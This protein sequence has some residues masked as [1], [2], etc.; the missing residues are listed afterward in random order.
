MVI[1]LLRIYFGGKDM[2]KKRLIIFLPFVLL[3]LFNSYSEVFP[4]NNNKPKKILYINSYYKDHPIESEITKGITESFKKDNKCIIY[5]EYMDNRIFTDNGSYFKTYIKEKY[6]DEDIDLIITA[7]D[8][9]L[10]FIDLNSKEI[11]KKSIPVVFCAI[12]NYNN[13]VEPYS[14]NYSG[15]TEKV[16]IESTFRLARQLN[17]NLE[18]AI[19]IANNKSDI[20]YQEEYKRIKNTYKDKVKFFIIDDKNLF[21]IIERIKP[22][23]Q[24][25]AI[26]FQGEYFD[27]NGQYLS[28]S[29]SIKILN[30]NLSI[31]IYSYWFA[32]KNFDIVGGDMKSSYRQGVM[33]GNLAKDILYKNTKEK[34][35]IN[36]TI[37]DYISENYNNFMLGH[38]YV[39]E[40]EKGD[41]NKEYIYTINSKILHKNNFN[42]HNLKVD[43]MLLGESK[44]HKYKREQ[45]LKIIYIIATFFFIVIIMFLVNIF[46]KKKDKNKFLKVIE[47]NEQVLEEVLTQERQRNELF[48]NIS[49]EFRTPLNVLYN[50]IQL[51]EYELSSI[52]S[53]EE[54]VIVKN[55]L[56][57][58]KHNCYRL[59]RL[60]NN[61]IKVTEI[62]NNLMKL[63]L[64]KVNIVYVIEDLVQEV[65]I[66]SKEKNIDRK[67]I[68]DTYIEEKLIYVDKEKIE[69][70]LLNLISN[71]VKFSVDG[72]TIEVILKEEEDSI[73]IILKDNGIGISEEDIED[74]F[75]KFSKVDKSL[76]RTKEGSGVGLFIVKNLLEFIEAKFNIYS[77]KGE[78]TIFNIEIPIK[79]IDDNEVSNIGIIV[80]DITIADKVRIEFSDIYI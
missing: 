66:Y 48:A 19:F 20:E 57:I 11:F 72:D 40:K 23:K 67:I 54:K 56:P 28:S 47:K 39:T 6:K 9:A 65:V 24:N 52:D 68:F 29:T 79:N 38:N 60:G 21:S 13:S 12:N 2:K 69:K 8:E 80:E 7:K 44:T 36:E 27:K 63:N 64:E 59:L 1:Y 32:Y 71:C 16:Q 22:I 75:N 55:R 25:S 45:L 5:T 78:G 70:V 34:K 76:N 41:Y 42:V 77:K 61:F 50:T 73:K 43:Y 17:E 49:H 10:R 14:K 62:E 53:L 58:I 35:I 51:I 37:K 31:P 33:A 15:I 18:N 30:E 4:L 3:F 74:I 26:F 46:L